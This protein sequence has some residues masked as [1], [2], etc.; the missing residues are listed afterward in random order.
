MSMTD[1]AEYWND[2]HRWTVYT[3]KQFYHIPHAECGHKHVN[4]A[5]AIEDVNCYSCLKLIEDGYNHQLPD[6]KTDFRSKAQK[7][8]ERRYKLAKIEH[9]KYGKCG[10]CDGFLKQRFNSVRKTFFLGC[11]NYPKCFYT[12]QL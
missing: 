8:R 1:T 3:G 11:E 6:G 7:K 4:T 12:K 9:E 10:H 2:V 5:L